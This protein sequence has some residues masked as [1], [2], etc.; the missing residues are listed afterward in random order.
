MT[1]SPHTEDK[2]IAAASP[3]DVP[4]SE[5]PGAEQATAN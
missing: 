1:V 4:K 3:A 2:S 5:K